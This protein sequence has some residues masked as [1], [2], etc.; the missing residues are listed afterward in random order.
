MEDG[1]NWAFIRLAQA[2]VASLSVIPVQ[3]VLG[4]GS[5]AR[6]NTPS[7]HEG[8]YRWRMQPG[9]LTSSLQ[10]KLAQLAEVCDRLPQPVSVRNDEN[11][12]A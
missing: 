5:E 1:V 3:D 10:E 6:L 8:N 12:A 2:S 4:L 9:S 7:T 11:F